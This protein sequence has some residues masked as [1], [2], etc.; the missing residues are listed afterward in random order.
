[1][2]LHFKYLCNQISNYKQFQNV[3]IWNSYS[4]NKIIKLS[5]ARCSFL[6]HRTQHRK[7]NILKCGKWFGASGWHIWNYKHLPIESLL[8]VLLLSAWCTAALCFLWRFILVVV[9]LPHFTEIGTSIYGAAPHFPWLDLLPAHCLC[10]GGADF[11]FQP[12]PW[13]CTLHWEAVSVLD[14]ELVVSDQLCRVYLARQ[15]VCYWGILSALL[16]ELYVPFDNRESKG[17]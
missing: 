13:P 6:R 3:K 14:M 10:L 16:G 11:T 1:M 5:V 8:G 4:I 17:R 7:I 9:H 2:N 15:T 12:W